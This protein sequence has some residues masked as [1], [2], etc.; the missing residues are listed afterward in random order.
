MRALCRIVKI[1]ELEY[2]KTQLYEVSYCM[3]WVICP[4]IPVCARA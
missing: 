2:R 4:G 3:V 1:T